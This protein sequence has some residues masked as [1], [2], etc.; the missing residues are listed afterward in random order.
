MKRN[1]IIF[2]GTLA[3]VTSVV[4]LAGCGSNSG[5]EKIG[6]TRASQTT[7]YVTDSPREDYAH[8]W[9]TIYHAEIVAQ[10]GTK[11][12][13][14]D[15]AAGH[16]IDLKTLRDAS[17]ALYS[18]L[19]S[20][21]LASG[22]YTGVNV[23]VGTTMQLIPTS[24]TT[25]TSVP[26][27][28]TI[29][30]DANSHLVLSVTFRKPKIVTATS[31]TSI[32]VDFDLARFIVRNS[33][34][35]PAL[36]EGTGEGLGRAD[37]HNKC[38]NAGTV[39]ALAGTAPDLSFTLTRRDGT[40]VVVNTTAATALSG[41]TAIANGSM[42]EVVGTV[43]STT[44]VLVAT[45]V[46]VRP[47]SSATGAKTPHVHGTASALNATAGTFSL[48]IVRADGFTVTT[49]S[50]NVITNASTTYQGDAGATQT[51]TEFFTALATTPNVSV[52]G[53]LD[54]VTNTLTATRAKVED[55]S[56]DGGWEKENHGFRGGKGGDRESWGN[57]AKPKR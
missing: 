48:V 30:L 53:T 51:Q 33:K 22:T 31:G 27:D 19:G 17:G 35:L 40:T 32:V 37:R 16:Q 28:A 23:T 13:L 18:F 55:G 25:G 45:S 15:D 44:Q 7:L 12:V 38:D 20:A 2:L 9:A 24:A 49:T 41:T 8:V 21:T 5:N 56:K 1:N 47:A 11:T 50:V 43:N 29:P 4:A 52:E 46:E 6:T 10:D 34:V 54:T 14:F 57:G 42:I 26:V 36:V 39:S 3:S